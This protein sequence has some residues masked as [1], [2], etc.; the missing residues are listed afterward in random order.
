MSKVIF[1]KDM[2]SHA[3]VT[4][5]RKQSSFCL[6]GSFTDGIVACFMGFF[7]VLETFISKLLLKNFTLKILKEK[8]IAP[9]PQPFADK[10]FYSYQSVNKISRKEAA[11][12]ETG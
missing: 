2:N 6:D 9:M 7:S 11:S 3:H 4:E 8:Q 5:T 1:Q 10:L 12:V